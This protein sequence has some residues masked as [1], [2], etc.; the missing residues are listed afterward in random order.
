MRLSDDAKKVHD[1]YHDAWIKANE[2][3]VTTGTLALRTLVLINGGAAITVLTFIGNVIKVG[4][5]KTGASLVG[6]SNALVTFAL[7]V[8]LATLA[9]GIGYVVNYSNA[10]I[11]S[12][13]DKIA[14]QPFVAETEGS[15][16]WRKCHYVLL[17]AAVILAILS[18]GCFM[19]GVMEV[20]CGIP[21]LL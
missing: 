19:I 16:F 17:P 21:L 3:A 10:G 11:S 6:I 20:K 7:G 15:A 13:T 1:R 18:L 9:I 5:L 8:A 14:K 12:R 2:A 4:Q